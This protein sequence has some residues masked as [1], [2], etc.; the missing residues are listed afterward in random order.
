TALTTLAP[1][2][3]RAARRAAICS[4]YSFS[5]ASVAGKSA[6]ASRAHVAVFPSRIF[7]SRHPHRFRLSLSLPAHP[8]REYRPVNLAAFLNSHSTPP[9]VLAKDSQPCTSISSSQSATRATAWLFS[10]AAPERAVV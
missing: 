2:A 4:R 7:V 9:D 3:L 6:P 1:V 5:P 8:N 10:Y